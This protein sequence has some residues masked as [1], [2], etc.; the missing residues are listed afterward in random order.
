MTGRV[1][2]VQSKG[3]QGRQKRKRAPDTNTL[4]DCGPDLV[5]LH[6][7]ITKEVQTLEQLTCAIEDADT[8][9]DEPVAD[10]FAIRVDG[11]TSADVPA[12]PACEKVAPCCSY[13]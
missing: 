9:E 8:D 12:E 13:V 11:K 2:T 10:T 1:A 7:A 6:K 3:F 4:E 5:S